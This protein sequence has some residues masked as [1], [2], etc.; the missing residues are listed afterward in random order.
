MKISKRDA[1]SWFTFFADLQESGEELTVRQQELALAALRQLELAAEAR[2]RAAAE[3]VQGLQ[4]MRGRTWYVGDPARFPKGCVSCLF[5]SGLS[6]VRKTNRFAM[7]TAAWTSSRR[8]G[9]TCGR[10]VG[11]DSHRRTCLS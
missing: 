1:L 8:W 10:S 3:K 2:H 11:R 5:G 4:S 9:R 6:A 7:T